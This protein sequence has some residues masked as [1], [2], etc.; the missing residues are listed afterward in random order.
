MASWQR[1]TRRFTPRPSRRRGRGRTRSQHEVHIPGR[2]SVKKCPYCAEEI[3]DEAIKCKHCGEWLAGN[4]GPPSVDT[5]ATRKVPR[6][7]ARTVP[8][9]SS[10]DSREERPVESG[11]ED[12]RHASSTSRCAASTG[13]PL[14]MPTQRQRSGFEKKTGDRAR[15]QEHATERNAAKPTGSPE[16]RFQDPPPSSRCNQ[17]ARVSP[18]HI[19]GSRGLTTSDSES[20]NATEQKKM[21]RA[22][23]EGRVP[24]RS[25]HSGT[26]LNRVFFMALVG[27]LL[28]AH[29]FLG[30]I[31]DNFLYSPQEGMALD[32]FT[33]VQLLRGFFSSPVVVLT[34]LAYSTPAI[35][36]FLA[37]FGYPLQRR[38]PKP[39]GFLPTIR[40]VAY[41]LALG[42]VARLLLTYVF[43]HGA[44]ASKQ[45]PGPGPLAREYH[46]AQD[47][48]RG[49]NELWADAQT[50]RSEEDGYSIRA[51]RGWE[52]FPDDA[53]RIMEEA[54]R[55]VLK[56]EIQY[57][58]GLQAPGKNEWQSPPYAF[59]MVIPY[60]NSGFSGQPSDEQLKT[61]V[62]QAYGEENRG[63]VLRKFKEALDLENGDAFVVSSRELFEESK[64]VYDEENRRVLVSSETD[65]PFY[66]P[67]MYWSISHFGRHASVKI[68]F[69]ALADEVEESRDARNLV[70]N[71]FRFL[72]G[73]E[74]SE[75]IA[76][77]SR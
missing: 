41:A 37:V 9:T 20:P 36:F 23:G 30:S 2:R 48:V 70:F 4:Q 34:G 35:L 55:E 19:D 14:P 63:W 1:S 68:D 54:A 76:Q 59:V 65:S 43:T 40:H 47:F 5:S 52:A 10:G 61:L 49:S 16:V 46:Q 38:L 50:L 69:F 28:L 45:T 31:Q 3:Q 15:Q 67:L 13:E 8:A 26:D 11:N 32:M 24:P 42:L 21:R 64:V 56:N 57:D 18:P 72:P 53:L 60:S 62:E 77:S 17:K 73:S 58:F 66:G 29:S 6:P 25:S 12:G 51:P 39:R 7:S 27:M 71:S 75:V 33:P 44:D 74:Y 22:A